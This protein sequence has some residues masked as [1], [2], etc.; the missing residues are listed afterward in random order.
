MFLCRFKG[1][2][3]KS[4]VLDIVCYKNYDP[5]SKIIKRLSTISVAEAMAIFMR[6]VNFIKESLRKILIIGGFEEYLDVKSMNCSARFSEIL[7]D[8][9]VKL[10]VTANAS[11][12]DNRRDAHNL[13]AKMKDVSVTRVNKMVQIIRHV[14]FISLPQHRC[15]VSFISFPPM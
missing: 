13:V 1:V 14:S 11:S 9:S 10:Q 7:N 5:R 2:N 15:V 12:I 8:Y 4:Q 3:G 6:I